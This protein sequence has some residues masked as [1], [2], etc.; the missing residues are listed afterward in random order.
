MSMQSPKDLFVYQLQDIYDAEQKI[1]QSLPLMA[2]EVQNQQVRSAFE[3]HVQETRQQISNLE[4]CFQELGVKPEKMACQTL[5]GLKQEHDNLL[6]ERPSEDLLAMFNLDNVAKAE[7]YEIASYKALI[8]KANLIGQKECTQL[9]QQ[10]LQQTEAMVRKIE[11]L[12]RQISQQM[13]SPKR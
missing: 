9:L 4:Q 12:G 7:H 2:K 8:E 3:Q 13:V 6:K 11:T 10:N 1:A 5:T